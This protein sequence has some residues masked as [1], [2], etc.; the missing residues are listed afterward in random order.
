MEGAKCYSYTLYKPDTQE[1]EYVIKQKGIT[2]DRANS[3]L[4]TFENVKNMVLKNETIKSAERYMFTWNNKNKDI[5]TKYISRTV[6][7]TMDSKR[8]II[9][10]DTLPFGFDENLYLN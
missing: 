9:G 3:N 2:L 4:F 5:E 7:S 8:T 1:C 10:T 6:R